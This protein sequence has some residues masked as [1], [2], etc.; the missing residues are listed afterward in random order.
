MRNLYLGLLHYPVY[1]KNKV[2]ITSA[3]TNFDIHDIS[4]ACKTFG[5]ENYFIITP[6]KGQQK[7][8]GQII[9]HWQEGFG[10]TYNSDRKDALNITFLID[11]LDDALKFIKEK[12]GKSPLVIATSANKTEKYSNYSISEFREF[13][14]GEGEPVLLL[15]GTGYGMVLE[16]LPQI[17]AML[18][19]IYGP[20]EYNHLSVRS[21][22]S[23]YLYALKG[24]LD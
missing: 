3:V 20:T 15:F 23:I 16:D 2:V 12:E 24:I 11:D 22:V 5:V 17:T 6:N 19:P 9:N 8:V 13:L 21:A 1:N 7:V 18:S 14:K 10:A 4:R